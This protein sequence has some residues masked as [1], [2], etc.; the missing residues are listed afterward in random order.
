MIDQ[1]KLLT[2][3]GTVMPNANYMDFQTETDW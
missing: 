3:Q 1:G 2:R